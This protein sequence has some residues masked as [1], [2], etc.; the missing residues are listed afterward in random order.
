MIGRGSGVAGAVGFPREG[1][2]A[3]LEKTE[4]LSDGSSICSAF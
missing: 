3:C 4:I 1:L 2:S